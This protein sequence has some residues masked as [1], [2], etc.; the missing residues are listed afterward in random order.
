LKN[1]SS[2]RLDQSKME[3]VTTTTTTTL[4]TLY[5]QA[6]TGKT[7][8][9]RIKVNQFADHSTIVISFGYTGSTR[10]I[11]TTRV[12]TKGKN[13]GKSNA[14][15]H[16]TQALAEANA[17]W[18]KKRDNEGFVEFEKMGAS[19]DHDTH[20]IPLPML[21][22]DFKKQSQKIRYPC[23]TQP[24][25]DGF[26][27]LYEPVTG[28]LWS[29]QSKEF[30]Y[31][32]HIIN[33]LQKLNSAL[34]LDGELYCHGN[35]FEDL[36]I[37]RKKKVTKED[38]QKMKKI[39]YHIYDVVDGSCEFKE[40][41]VQLELLK[42]Q[43]RT[44]NLKSICI[45]D[46]TLVHSEK[47]IRENHLKNITAGYEGTMVRNSFG[48]YLQKYR[49][50]DLQKYKD[51][52]DH[53]FCI[54]DFAKEQGDLIVFVCETESGQRFHVPGK[55]TREERHQVYLE[56]QSHP[57]RFLNKKLWVQFFEYTAD[58]I[59]RFPKTY[60]NVRESIRISF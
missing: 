29:R 31:C 16:Y 5:C 56:T 2:S 15:T 54:V 59:P 27:C 40:R 11:E 1:K 22:H 4:P 43:I 44:L 42:K 20:S 13:A 37:L 32:D 57:E 26:R 52:Q 6:K 7:K 47:D 30:L 10:F 3:S 41:L 23:Y 36:G 49:S 18:T 17:K 24:K 38:L 19:L 14:T 28:K 60:R 8:E 25:L 33:D 21:A 58:Q 51:F 34:I 9:W 53:E 46:T 55:G 45:V 12:I 50:Y 35:P 48:C 39:T